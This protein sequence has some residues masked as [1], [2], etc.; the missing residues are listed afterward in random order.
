MRSDKVS[1]S[2]III[3]IG[4]GVGGGGRAGGMGAKN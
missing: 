1:K 3:I 4:W 2:E